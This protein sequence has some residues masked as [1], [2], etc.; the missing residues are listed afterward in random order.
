MDR[1][2]DMISEL[3]KLNEVWSKIG[4]P[5]I[6]TGIGIN[7]GDMSVGNMGSKKIFSYTVMGDAVNLA[8]RI[9]GITKEYHARLLIREFTSLTYRLFC[10]STVR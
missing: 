2:L 10:T 4:L 3:E 1:A 8:S 5:K 6:E 9:E 7:T